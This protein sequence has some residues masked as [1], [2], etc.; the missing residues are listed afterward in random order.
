MKITP[1]P[2]HKKVK[3]K[4]LQKRRY[5][6]HLKS[7]KA[8]GVKLYVMVTVK[9]QTATTKVKFKQCMCLFCGQH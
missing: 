1:F 5:E 9:V 4:K 7:P 8:K 2:D 3:F 6:P